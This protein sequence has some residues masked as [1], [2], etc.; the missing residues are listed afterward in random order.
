[1]LFFYHDRT[2]MRAEVFFCDRCL[3][4]TG[5]RTLDDS[6]QDPI[7]GL[8]MIGNAHVADFCGSSWFEYHLGR[9]KLIK[10]IQAH[11]TEFTAICAK[12][13]SW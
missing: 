4:G 11:H 9:K 1:M 6:E 10:V 7:S 5:L 2:D 12:F 13:G 8:E 3:L